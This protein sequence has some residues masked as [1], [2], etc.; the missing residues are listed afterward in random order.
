MKNRVYVCIDLKSFYASVECRERNLD[1][2]KTNLVVADSSRTEKTVCLAIT[3]TMKEYGLSG[4]ARLF[5]VL[6]KVREINYKRLKNNNYKKFISKSYFQE[7]LETNS[8]LEVDF[9]IAAPQMKKYMNYSTKIYNTYLKYLSKDDIFVYS[10]DEVFC[11]ITNYLNIHKI[12]AYEFVKKMINDV[13]TK[14]GITATAGIGTNLF[15]CKIAMDIVAKH[16]KPDEIGVRI[17][18]LDEMSFKKQL[19]D[20]KPLTDFWRIG[21]GYSK[22]LEEYNMHTM[23]DIALCSINNE[24]LLYKLFG[25]NAELLIDHAWGYEPCTME[26]I[27]SYKPSTSSLSSGQVLHCPYNFDQTRLIV[28]EMIDSL[29][30]DLV[31]KKLITNQLVLTINYDILN[32]SDPIISRLYDGVITTDQY[33]RNVPKSAHGTINFTYT[34]STKNLMKSVLELYDKISNKKLLSRKINISVNNL[35]NESKYEQ[36]RPKYEQF[37]LFKDYSTFDKE[38]QS[39]KQEIVEERKLQNVLLDIKNK[40]G[41]NSILKGMNFEEYATSRDRNGQVGGHKG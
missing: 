23:G 3:P 17:A 7:E 41:K 11:D 18:E 8:R 5:E 40:Y 21:K 38:K 22:K 15:L 13:Y 29:S 4:R 34:S 2:L 37:D 31:A 9:I 16:K 1:P 25:I 10:I 19:W 24:D 35:I 20:H 27:K 39:E 14:T 36:V 28:K 26:S 33:G 6:Q 32:L 30:L 12:T